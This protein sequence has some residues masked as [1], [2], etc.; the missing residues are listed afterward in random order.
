V[1]ATQPSASTRSKGQSGV[2]FNIVPGMG[3]LLIWCGLRRDS[4]N[5]KRPDFNSI[6]DRGQGVKCGSKSTWI[7]KI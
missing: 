4:P 3:E 5:L 1:E 2:T 7:K 6:C